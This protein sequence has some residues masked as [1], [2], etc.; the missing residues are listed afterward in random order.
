LGGRLDRFL[1]E[2]RPSCLCMGVNDLFCKQINGMRNKKLTALFGLLLLVMLQACNSSGNTAADGDGVRLQFNLQKGKTYTYSMDMDMESE[3]QGQAMNN[4]MQFDY[5]VEVLDAQDSVKTLKTTYDHISMKIKAGQMDL[6]FDTNEPQ[7]DSAADFRTNPMGVMSN[8]FYA[9]KGKS[10]EM[11]INNQG[12]VLAITGLDELRQAM[13]NSLGGD[14]TVQQAMGQAFQQQFNEENIKS[15]F[16]QAFSIFPDK[17][18]KVGDSWTKKMS[19][20]APMA[21]E[22]NTTYKVKEI[23]NNEV[24]L[25]VASDIN[26]GDNKGKQTGTMK[27]EPNTGLV[28]EAVLEQKL[29]NPVNMTTKTKIIGKEN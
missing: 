28:T 29:S 12:E 3:M 7:K 9:M 25:D 17:A 2:N 27:L 14:E 1:C 10:F 5:T 19:M 13:M 18:V 20:G 26:M 6:S 4:D 11:K 8:M 15:S 24:V 23:N 21:S 22:M 16:S